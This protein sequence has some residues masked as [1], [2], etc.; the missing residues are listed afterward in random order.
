MT[1]AEL[2][3]VLSRLDPMTQVHVEGAYH[4]TEIRKRG[5]W[6]GNL[7]TGLLIE[8]DAPCV[9]IEGRVPWYKPE[10]AAPPLLRGRWPTKPVPLAK[11]LERVE[12][13]LALVALQRL[14]GGA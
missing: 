9:V 14:G 8:N 7:T 2:V 5:K 1:A 4:V 3:D 13:A 11:R 10:P 6:K 12:R